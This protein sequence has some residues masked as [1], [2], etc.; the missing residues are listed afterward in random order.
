MLQTESF[1]AGR[2][3]QALSSCRKS[4]PFR[5]LLFRAAQRRHA[6]GRRHEHTERSNRAPSCTPKGETEVEM[7]DIYSLRINKCQNLY[8]PLF[9]QN[10]VRM[11][12][13]VPADNSHCSCSSC[14]VP[15]TVVKLLDNCCLEAGGIALPTP[16]CS[17][18]GS[19]DTELTDKA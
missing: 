19:V 5:S 9:R 14:R 18:D 15:E 6:Q 1:K 3:P 7:G 2:K 17:P 11:K 10:P 4:C 13:Y 8:P 16:R 12:K